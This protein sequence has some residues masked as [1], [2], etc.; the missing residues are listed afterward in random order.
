MFI[1]LEDDF[2]ERG[3]TTLSRQPPER[4]KETHRSRGT[5][6]GLS[7]NRFNVQKKIPIFNSELLLFELR[8]HQLL[9]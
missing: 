2:G 3:I 4:R 8:G 7:L 9:K 6:A 5:Y 1:I